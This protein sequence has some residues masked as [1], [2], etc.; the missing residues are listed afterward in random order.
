M[1][2]ETMISKVEKLSKSADN[3]GYALVL[4]GDFYDMSEQEQLQI[5]VDTYTTLLDNADLDKSEFA[6][7]IVRRKP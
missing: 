6:Q 5:V 7:L 3:M 1:S 2:T 4:R